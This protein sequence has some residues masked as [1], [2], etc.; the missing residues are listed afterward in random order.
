MIPSGRKERD[1]DDTLVDNNRQ[2]RRDFSLAEQQTEAIGTILTARERIHY[3][4]GVTG[5]GK[6]EIFLQVAKRLHGEGRGVIY[7][8]PEISLVHQVV[9]VFVSEFREAVAVLHSGLTAS[10][11]LREWR[12]LMRGEVRIVIGARSAVF[13]PVSDLGLIIIDE[14]HE[15]TY[16]SGFAPRYHARQVASYRCRARNAT[17]V[18]GSATPRPGW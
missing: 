12:R 1:S 18:L 8:V 3:V 10:Q 5:S 6:T 13:A 2:L 15:G 9:E 17:L 7:L 14:E 11:R 16:K 4:Q